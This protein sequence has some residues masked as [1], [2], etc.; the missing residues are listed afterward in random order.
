QQKES[1]AAFMFTQAFEA[2]EE[3]LVL[4]RPTLEEDR[5]TLPSVFLR[6]VEEQVELALLDVPACLASPRA[7]ARQ[8]VRQ[9]AGKRRTREQSAQLNEWRESLASYR[10]RDGWPRTVSVEAAAV[11][12]LLFPADRPFSPS[13]LETYAACGFR[14]FGDRILRLKEHDPD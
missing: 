12:R 2:A 3:R 7:A 10:Q 9:E 6:A 13:E 1:E 14:Y 11:M 8:L 4:S 5:P